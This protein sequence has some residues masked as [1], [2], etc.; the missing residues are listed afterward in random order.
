MSDIN[1]QISHC[2]P[3]G[4]ARKRAERVARQLKKRFALDYSW[5]GDSLEFTRQGVTGALEVTPTEAVV[6]IRLGLLLGFLKPQ[7]EKQIRHELRKVFEPSPAAVAKPTATKR[8][9]LTKSARSPKP[10][11]AARRKR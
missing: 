6:R 10:Q 3:L 2:I 1:I 8:A 4:R 7:I 5:S 9:P 11:S